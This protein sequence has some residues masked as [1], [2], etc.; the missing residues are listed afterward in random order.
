MYNKGPVLGEVGIG[1]IYVF[2]YL[3]GI[4]FKLSIPLRFRKQAEK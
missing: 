2:I 1:F 3:L 4:G